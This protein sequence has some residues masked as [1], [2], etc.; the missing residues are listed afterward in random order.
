MDNGVLEKLKVIIEGN[1]NPYKQTIDEAKAKTKE[2][3]DSVNKDIARIKNPI[4]KMMESSPELQNM[5]NLISN[6]LKDGLN[7]NIASGIGKG[8]Y[9][10]VNEAQ[11]KIRDA[12]KGY[13]LNSGIKE[14]T[15]D[16]FCLLYTSDAA[17]E[18]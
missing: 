13:Q 10:K 17:D 1:A 8:I 5:K 11:T 4:K 18:L 7:G 2:M 9:G 12:L 16:Y 14:K 15:D 3:T 6:S